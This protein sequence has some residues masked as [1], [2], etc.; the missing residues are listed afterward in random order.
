MKLQIS[1]D[2]TDL[3]QALSIAKKVHKYCDQ[4]E[5][6]SLMLYQNGIQAIEAFREQ[7]PDKALVAD[8]KIIDRGE[9]ITKIM[10]KAGADWITVMGGT[11]KNVLYTVARAAERYKVKVMVDLI[12]ANA[13]G[14]TAM[15]AQG[16]GGD[17]ILMHK[18]HDEG[19]SFSFLDEWDLVR[20]NTKLPIFIGA[21]INRTNIKKIIDLKPDGIVVG[22]SIIQAE[23]PLQ[24]AKFFYNLCHK[25]TA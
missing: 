24:E 13:P 22:H 16:F 17:A 15:E 12:D 8:T 11:N 20:G 2:M 9:E 7:F 21:K 14:Q 4:F 6:G 19:D 5:V 18:P 23:N 1:F 10:A 25:H 3:E